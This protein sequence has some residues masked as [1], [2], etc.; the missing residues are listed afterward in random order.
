MDCL[1]GR[2]AAKGRGHE[3]AVGRAAGSG[4]GGAG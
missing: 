1:L 3:A 4:A 2:D